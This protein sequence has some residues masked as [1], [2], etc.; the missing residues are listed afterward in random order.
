MRLERDIRY[1]QDRIARAIV[2]D[3]AAQPKD[4]VGFGATVETED[5]EGHPPHASRS[6]ARMR[7]TPRSASCRGS[8]R[9][10]AR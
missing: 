1:V 8:R 5:D 10:R 7:P 2:I 6:W 9:W 3:P 4:R